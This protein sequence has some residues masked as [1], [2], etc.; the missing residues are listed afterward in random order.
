M[1][2]PDIQPIVGELARCIE[3]QQ[4]WAAGCVYL[5]ETGDAEAAREA[6][7]ESDRWRDRAVAIEDFIRRA[8]WRSTSGE[9]P[10]IR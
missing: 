7:S 2:G 8:P 5:H 9:Q 1:R 4:R 10:V 6:M 3:M